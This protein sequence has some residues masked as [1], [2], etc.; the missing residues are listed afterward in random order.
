MGKQSAR[1]YYQGN[2]H[3][4]IYFQGKYH[5]KMYVGNQLVWEKLS[6]SNTYIVNV[7]H[8]FVAYTLVFDFSRFTTYKMPQLGEVAYNECLLLYANR[9]FSGKIGNITAPYQS[10]YISK[11]NSIDF[12]KIELSEYFPDATLDYSRF[13]IVGD[14]LYIGTVNDGVTQIKKITFSDDGQISD[15]IDFY[16]HSVTTYILNKFYINNNANVAVYAESTF[17]NLVLTNGDRRIVLNELGE[18]LYEIEPLEYE[19][20][21]LRFYSARFG[22]DDKII[23]HTYERERSDGRVYNS[24]IYI[25]NK[26]VADNLFGAVGKYITRPPECVIIKAQNKY[27][28]Y[29]TA[30]LSQRADGHDSKYECSVYSSADWSTYKK[31][32]IQPLVIKADNAEKTIC[33]Y[34]SHEVDKN[35]YVADFYCDLYTGINTILHAHYGAVYFNKKGIISEKENLNIYYKFSTSDGEMYSIFATIDPLL[36]ESIDNHALLCRL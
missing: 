14:D 32:E 36:R 1:L 25:G 20:G 27:Y 5:D 26:I 12:N 30:S 10:G 4:D 7:Y 13:A 15:T 24:R 35:T 21:H 2:D 31:E 29:Y 9:W 22:I 34:F 19:T 11:I 18:I 8:N 17:G 3:K 6:T 33:F 16:T 28:I 23:Y